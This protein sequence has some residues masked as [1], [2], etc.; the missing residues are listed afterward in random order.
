MK[1]F[2]DRKNIG[3]LLF[4]ILSIITFSVFVWALVNSPSKDKYNP[5][6]ALSHDGY[7]NTHPV[8]PPCVDTESKTTRQRTEREISQTRAEWSDLAAQWES[9]DKAHWG[10]YAVLL[11]ISLLF[12]TLFETL[13]AGRELGKQNELSLLSTKAEFQP[14]IKI[15]APII[16]PIV[17]S[18]SPEY[19]YTEFSFNVETTIE[20]I[21][22]TPAKAVY[23][24]S[25]GQFNFPL[26]NKEGSILKSC[27]LYTSPSPRDQRGSRMPSSA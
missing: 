14:Q 7:T 15:N 13:A 4:A 10:F 1:W 8:L 19:D 20:N 11:G 26:N 12:W 6:S 5:Y 22:R 27:L 3:T 21:G 9:A 18:T 2:E 25:A 23:L 17:T 24:I 16:G